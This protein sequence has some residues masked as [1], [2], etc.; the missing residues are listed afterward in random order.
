MTAI[1]GKI[2]ELEF[3]SKEEFIKVLTPSNKTLMV[4]TFLKSNAKVAIRILLKE[5][6]E[7][8]I[9]NQKIE[10]K[11]SNYKKRELKL[12]KDKSH[13]MLDKKPFFWLSDTWWLALCG[14]LSLEEFKKLANIRKNQ[15][16]NVI[17][18]VAGLFPD[19]DSFD[20]RG[21]NSGGFAWNKDYSSINP[22]FFD[23]AEEK[24]K[25]L[26]E[27][28]FHIALVGSWGYYL[29]KLGL[30]KIK[31]HWRY[32][33]ARWGVYCSIYIAAGEATMPYYLS[34]KRAKE[35]KE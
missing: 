27:L 8:S 4:P 33:I 22:A 24:I 11:E 3:D 16:F 7:Y 25:Y 5:A 29:Q 23:E 9:N 10:V 12:S 30:E 2:L 31:E 6:G 13:L 15:G 35:S 21:S 14:R 28:G 26:Y 19:M 1:K 18:L 17:Q 34:T 32:L 20:I